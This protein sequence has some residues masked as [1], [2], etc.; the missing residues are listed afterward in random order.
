MNISNITVTV[1]DKPLLLSN[2]FVTSTKL[3]YLMKHNLDIGEEIK[4]K[5]F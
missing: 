2:N 4:K 1:F 5:H 3:S